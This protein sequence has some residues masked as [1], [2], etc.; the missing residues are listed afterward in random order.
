LQLIVDVEVPGK[1]WAALAL[2]DVERLQASN[3]RPR[4]PLRKRLCGLHRVLREVEDALVEVHVIR[5]TD[6]G[7]L[8]EVQLPLLHLLPRPRN[9][10]VREARVK[11]FSLSTQSLSPQRSPAV[12]VIDADEEFIN[13]ILNKPPRRCPVQALNLT[14]SLR[15]VGEPFSPLHLLQFKSG[16]RITS[17]REPDEPLLRSIEPLSLSRE[18]IPQH[19]N[20]AVKHFIR[21]PIQLPKELLPSV[22]DATE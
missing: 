4:N 18:P 12:Q 3:R 19:P 1:L 13:P 2:Q 9:L 6:A 21:E 22:K 20:A 7:E 15:E 8:T 5:S 10:C 16:E 11:V 14:K 17:T